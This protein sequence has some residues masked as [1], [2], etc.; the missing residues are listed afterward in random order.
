MHKYRT[1]SILVLVHMEI[2]AEFSFKKGKEFIEKHHSD[3]KKRF[4]KIWKKC[5]PMLRLIAED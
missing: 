2:V 1:E 5:A 3:F 4:S